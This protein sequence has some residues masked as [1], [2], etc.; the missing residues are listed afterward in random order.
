[1]TRFTLGA[2]LVLAFGLL[3]PAGAQTQAERLAELMS[4][5]FASQAI[6]AVQKGDRQAAIKLAVRGFPPDPTKEEMAGLPESVFALELAV[7]ARL[8]RIDQDGFGGFSVNST[9]TRAFA[10]HWGDYAGATER[11]FPQAI[12][13]A[14]DGT[15]IKELDPQID[16]HGIT[17]PGTSPSFS[18]DGSIL[19]VPSNKTFAVHLYGSETGEHLGELSPGFEVRSSGGI[20]YE[21][22]FSDDGSQYA[23]GYDAKPGGAG[24]LVWDVATRSLIHNLP[25]DGG[26]NNRQYPLGWDHED[27]FVVQTIYRESSASKPHRVALERWKQDGDR[28]PLLD[29]DL[30]SYD[31][32]VNVFL[33]PSTGLLLLSDQHELRAV[34]LDTGEVRFTVPAALPF[35]AL[36]RDG[37]AFA[38]R[39]RGLMSPM[40]YPVVDLQGG[41]LTTEGRDVVAFAHGLF[42][43][44]GKSI[45]E[46]TGMLDTTY[47]GENL[48]LGTE[49]YRLAW[50]SLTEA[51]RSEVDLD[52]VMRP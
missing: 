22:G 42:S 8:I 3:A 49:L 31:A 41:V 35:V 9:G 10:G 24:I 50:E 1:M 29:T 51:D 14:R 40:E 33:Y 47:V 36:V 45:G 30:R 34:D 26:R 17:T 37:T 38:L 4:R 11:D 7:G 48:P 43:M 32:G 6:G 15:R 13:D 52:R 18:P 5:D 12:L 46:A 25:M 44:N 2:L 27:G 19:A 28:T 39:P 23:R 20:G 16:V 21:I